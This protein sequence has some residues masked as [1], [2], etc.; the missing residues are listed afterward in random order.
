MAKVKDQIFDRSQVSYVDAAGRVCYLDE[1]FRHI[2][3]DAYPLFSLNPV[4]VARKSSRGHNQPTQGRGSPDQLPYRMCFQDCADLWRALPDECPAVPLCN[5]PSSKKSIWEAK[6]EQ[7][8]MCSYYD[9]FMSC[10]MKHCY[11]ISIVGPDGV[12]FKGGAIS[13]LAAC[14]PCE[15]PCNTSELS[16]G[17]TTD[18]MTVGSSQTLT[19]CD[20]FY[21]DSV[22]CCRPDDLMW[23]ILTGGG[24][25]S[26]EFGS[27][28]TYYA[29]ADISGCSANPTIRLSD[30]C[31]R[32]AELT[33]AVTKVH[34]YDA[35]YVPGQGHWAGTLGYCNC[36]Y[37]GYDWK[38]Y[39]CD[40]VYRR[41]GV[42]GLCAGPE[43]HCPP[44]VV[45]DECYDP[46]CA[47]I[48][49]V[50]TPQQILDGCCPAVFK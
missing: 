36:Y 37:P 3:P 24:S 33:T 43:E 21:G 25:L 47:A 50:R 20:S 23:E 49:D 35:Y 39:G 6:Q 19:A 4:G 27:A 31:G 26:A 28:V 17:Y 7:G 15:S 32:S 42:Y 45:G 1:L 11:E 2:M 12:G 46:T 5:G 34:D 18:Q 8:V 10:C 14:W 38:Y 44:Y 29:P 40:G 22:P 41:D 9:L 30:C 16:I 13:S 48:K